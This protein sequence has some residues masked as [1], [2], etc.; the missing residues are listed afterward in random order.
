MATVQLPRATV[1]DLYREEGK[2]ELIGGRIVRF[3]AHGHKPS[4][5]SFRIAM[6]LYGYAA[7]IGK[8]VAHPDGMGY[9]VPELASGRESF[10]PDASFYDGPLPA[11]DMRFI[12]GPPTFA[13][14]T[15]SEN[16]YGPAKEAE[17]A[18]KRADYFAAG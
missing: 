10:E 13:N 15:R 3:M 1:D 9:I 7:Q 8:G 2:A 18:E 5:V 11:N 6:S 17:M 12:D 14:E 16:D 4:Q